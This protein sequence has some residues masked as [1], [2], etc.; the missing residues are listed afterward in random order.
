MPT[1]IVTTFVLS[2]YTEITMLFCV[3]FIWYTKPEVL[4]FGCVTPTNLIGHT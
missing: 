4:N 1:I 3:V 2:T